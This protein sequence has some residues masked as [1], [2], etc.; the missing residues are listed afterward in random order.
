M[1]AQLDTHPARRERTGGPQSS[2]GEDA[3]VAE[4]RAELHKI[5][6]ELVNRIAA[7]PS[8]TVQAVEAALTSTD[9][10]SSHWRGSLRRDSARE[11]YR[12]LS[13]SLMAPRG[14]RR[15]QARRSTTGP[16]A[17]LAVVEGEDEDSEAGTDEAKEFV[18]ISSLEGDLEAAETRRSTLL[19]RAAESDSVEL[20]A[21]GLDALERTVQRATR[22]YQRRLQHQLEVSKQLAVRSRRVGPATPT[23]AEGERLAELEALA[24]AELSMTS[25]AVGEELASALGQARQLVEAPGMRATHARPI[26]VTCDLR[27]MVTASPSLMQRVEADSEQ[28]GIAARKRLQQLRLDEVQR[29]NTAGRAPQRPRPSNSSAR[30]ALKTQP[31]RPQSAALTSPRRSQADDPSSVV[32]ARLGV[33]AQ[34]E[35]RGWAAQTAAER[36]QLAK[37]AGKAPKAR[38][39]VKPPG[40]HEEDGDIAGVSCEEAVARLG[41]YRHAEDPSRQRPSRRGGAGTWTR[42]AMRARGSAAGAEQYRSGG[43]GLTRQLLPQ[44]SVKTLHTDSG[45]DGGAGAVEWEAAGPT[46]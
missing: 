9:A 1:R 45:S 24:L 14:S 39:A 20:G 31:Q 17:E 3:G 41:R 37:Q 13:S 43:R 36:M 11:L 28:R 38:A 42:P 6:A 46:P 30:L 18:G 7:E 44:L 32:T 26:K 40:E 27:G 23:A 4:L 2:P 21:R 12:V 35:A 15:P 5:P 16:D 29:P 34:R 19:G 10:A 33:V 25:A 8:A 22:A